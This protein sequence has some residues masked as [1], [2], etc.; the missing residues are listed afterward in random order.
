MVPKFIHR[1]WLGSDVPAEFEP[2]WQRWGGLFPDYEL[3]TWR[4]GDLAEL[5]MPPHFAAAATY[6]ERSDIARLEILNRVGGIYVDCDAEP[7]RR[8]DHLWTDRDRLVLFEFAPGEFWNGCMAAEPGGAAFLARFVARNVHRHAADAS[9]VVRTGPEAVRAALDYQLTK[10]ARGIRIC[11]PAFLAFGDTDRV[12]YARLGADHSDA[13][14]RTEFRSPPHWKTAPS[15]EPAQPSRVA[16]LAF[17]ARL[18][19]LRV[20]RALLR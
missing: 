19:P 1:I 14:M 11:P 16:A 9:P 3:R 17:D 20:R 15:H 2:T 4:E 18:M 5:G 13:V 6:A 12:V 7:L 10:D 8:F